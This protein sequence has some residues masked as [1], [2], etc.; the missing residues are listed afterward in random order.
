MR[1]FRDFVDVLVVL[2]IIGSGIVLGQMVLRMGRLEDRIDDYL[3]AHGAASEL[4]AIV[5]GLVGETHNVEMVLSPI[6]PTPTATAE[7]VE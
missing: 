5:G 2:W 3:I 1:Y 7:E 6:V 4:G